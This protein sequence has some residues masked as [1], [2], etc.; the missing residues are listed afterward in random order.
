M[1]L[2]IPY[3]HFLNQSNPTSLIKNKGMH[4]LSVFKTGETY[5][6]PLN[7]D[8]NFS[9]LAPFSLSQHPHLNDISPTV[10]KENFNWREITPDDTPAQA[11]VKKSIT[12]PPN[13]YLCGSCWAVS[14]STSL[15]DC[16]LVSGKVS[17]NP[18]ISATY[19]LACYSQSKCGGGNAAVL[20]NDIADHGIGS[21]H[22]VDY[23]WCSTN[24]VCNGD[25]KH[26]F[27]QKI[28][29]SQFIP[30]CG[31]Y[32]N[33][34]KHLIF[35]IA[36]SPKNMYIG[37]SPD[38]T[39]DNF[40]LTLKKHIFS[41]GPVVG[42]YLVYGNFMTGAFTRSKAT[43]GVYLDSALYN[44][45]GTVSFPAINDV[46]YPLASS[47]YKGSHAVSI[48]GWGVAKSI[49]TS[50]SKTEDVPYWYVRNSWGPLWGDGGF[51][52]IAMYPHNRICQ[53][54]N[55]VQIAESL[56]TVQ[57]GGVILYVPASSALVAQEDLVFNKSVYD[58]YNI[59]EK[60]SQSKAFYSGENVIPTHSPNNPSPIPNQVSI[61]EKKYGILYT[62]LVVSAIVLIV[63]ILLKVILTLIL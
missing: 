61:I 59:Q 5:I 13:Q 42:A 17:S 18:L 19:A 28:D 12:Q 58:T 36:P 26:H 47:N 34:N 1:A 62:L 37:S 46:N 2:N 21:D 8:M 7:A 4:E 39:I 33:S 23:S 6:P 53:F 29:L 15:A 27:D 16:F 52:K 40:A 41:V 9:S 32:D 56:G 50:A 55:L 30:S 51:F 54:D 63:L 10:L 14:S 35:Y 24:G 57:A 49:S 45:D 31:C 38:I 20:A 25:P 43:K 60:M 3:Q 11:L 22:C 44:D 48:I